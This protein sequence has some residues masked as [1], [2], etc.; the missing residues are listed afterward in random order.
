MAII[1]NDNFAVNVGKPVDSKYL[2]GQ[3]PW[4][5]TALVNAGISQP[6]R[7]TGLTVNILGTEYWYKTGVT[8]SSL[9]EKKYNST[10]PS[11]NFVTGGTNLGFFSGF[12]G[13]QS[14]LLNRAG[15][16]DYDGW[17][18]STYGWYYRGIDGNIYAG[19]PSDG[20]P[21]RAYINP[22]LNKSWIWNQYT[23]NSVDQL[24]WILTDGNIQNYL[25]LFIN[26]VTYY[27][28]AT[29]FIQT[30]WI[31]GTSPSQGNIMIDIIAGSLTT[32][33]TIT[34]GV[35]IFAN[36]TNNL[37]NFR[38]LQTKTPDMISISYDNTFVYLSGTT[39]NVANG[40]T[41]IGNT[42]KL[43]GILTDTTTMVRGVGN[44]AGIEYGGDYSANYT[45]RS[46]VDKG[47]VLSLSSISSGSG[48]R[49]TKSITQISHG[50]VINDV[51]GWSGGTYNKAIANGQYDGEVIGIVT[52]VNGDIFDL[53]Q[54]GYVTGLTG[55]VTN[56]TY[57][58]SD[59]TAGL[60]TSIE[61]TADSHISKAVIMANS[62]TS[63]WVLPYA[64]VTISSGS[65]V[66]G[67]LIR[68]V[69]I[70]T[71]SYQ[72]TNNDFFI[73]ANNS[74]AISLPLAPPI[75]MVVVVADVCNNA[76]SGSPITIMGSL[77][78]GSAVSYIST[79]S[80]S[81]SY[82]YN[83]TKWNVFAFTPAIY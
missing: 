58:L 51:I 39:A 45:N 37:L 62:S 17:Y 3:L 80:G 19:T 69:C 67:P 63:G 4:L 64:G 22:I 75:G 83:G 43:G 41:K 18:Y 74:I 23:G 6:Y 5:S 16:T 38:T 71:I 26:G 59:T 53:T 9:V 2:N 73:G 82:V 13:V 56:T 30:S 50:F 44:T 33:T 72:V 68:S 34:V 7:Y 20:I 31:S 32:G 25:G 79:A 65:S 1:I 12:T 61:P 49:I 46:L 24:G 60:L 15:G 47:Y 10:I 36:K 35:P 21:K 40:L 78:N 66:G 77:V 42:I 55:L 29:P 57:F 70:P 27:P 8:N 14:L 11:G 48:E 52:K 28:P 81:L 76:S 54:V